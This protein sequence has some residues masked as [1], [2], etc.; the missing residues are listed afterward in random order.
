MLNNL[1]FNLQQ[2]IA[3]YQI[4][5]DESFDMGEL[6]MLY[7]QMNILKWFLEWILF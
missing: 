4:W 2:S 3:Q 5:I 1:I 7:Q 6:V